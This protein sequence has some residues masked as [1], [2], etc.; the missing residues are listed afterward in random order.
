MS[1]NPYGVAP[2]PPDEQLLMLGVVSETGDSDWV[3]VRLIVNGE[4]HT[5]KLYVDVAGNVVFRESE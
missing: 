2:N 3:T 4:P 5:G 1:V